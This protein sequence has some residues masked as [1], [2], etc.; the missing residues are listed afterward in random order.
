MK[1][2]EAIDSNNTN[3]QRI[4]G[5]I[6]K[7]IKN[8]NIQ[9]LLRRKSILFATGGQEKK[10]NLFTN[11]L[12]YTGSLFGHKGDI[13]CLLPIIY[14]KDRNIR[15][16]ELVSSGDDAKIKIWDLGNNRKI[17]ISTLPSS[18]ISWIRALCLPRPRILIS[19]S[20]DTSLIIWDLEELKPIRTLSGHKLGIQAILRINDSQVIS[21]D[22]GGELKI[23]DIDQGICIR[24]M[25]STPGL[26]A[27]KN[28]NRYIG[29]STRYTFSLWELESS[30]PKKKYILDAGFSIE[31]FPKG[32]SSIIRGMNSGELE[33]LDLENG[34]WQQTILLHSDYIRCILRM[35]SDIVIT[36]SD[37][38]TLKVI[39][40][41]TAISYFEFRMNGGWIYS[42]AKFN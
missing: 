38:H 21:G 20:D 12:E 25:A 8:R 16:R 7:Y 14:I 22:L 23:W 32:D 24:E 10:I 2:Q 28:F 33:I 9:E 36:A 34:N 15:K 26:L 13:R 30:Q 42:L 29:C 27:M 40:I 18:H 41:S 37:D 5:R 39:D 17:L 4:H 19:G 6:R 11:S 1:E 35:V 3:Y 31:Y